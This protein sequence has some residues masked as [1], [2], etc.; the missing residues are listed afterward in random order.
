MSQK[1]IAKIKGSSCGKGTN[2]SGITPGGLLERGG[3]WWGDDFS[4]DEERKKR[5]AEEQVKKGE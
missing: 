3:H 4:G 2:R 5:E 1:L